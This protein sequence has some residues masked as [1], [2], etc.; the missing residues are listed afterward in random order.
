M[1]SSFQASLKVIQKFPITLAGGIRISWSIPAFVAPLMPR[2]E[3]HRDITLIGPRHSI[4]GGATSDLPQSSVTS[5]L[6]LGSRDRSLRAM[7]GLG[8]LAPHCP[9][10]VISSAAWSNWSDHRGTTSPLTAK[11]VPELRMTID[12]H[13]SNWWPCDQVRGTCETHILASDLQA[14]QVS[15]FVRTPPMQTP[16]L[17]GVLCQQAHRCLTQSSCWYTCM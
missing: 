4:I 12:L 17:T 9:T 13:L 10:C 6:V 14:R 7:A 15:P 5:A 1:P 3:G 8:M 16:H 2:M 11:N